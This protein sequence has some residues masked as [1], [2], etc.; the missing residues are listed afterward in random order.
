MHQLSPETHAST[1]RTSTIPVYGARE[2]LDSI[3][4]QMAKYFVLTVRR[5]QALEDSIDQIWRREKQE[6]LRPLKVRLG[7]DEGED[8]LDHGG[9]Q[10]EFFKLVFA[11]AFRTD[12]GMF[13]V[14]SSTHMTWFQPGTVEQLYKFEVIGI[15]TSLAVYNAV[16]LPSHN[17]SCVLS[18]IA[19]TQGEETGAHQGW[20]ARSC[21][22][23]TSA[24]G[25]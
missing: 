23:T 1:L 25:L 9:V 4:P 22:R 21:E 13:D 24:S 8:G 11:E 12:Y 16:T 18:Q 19:W 10:Q 7:K 20:L 6:I 17:A 3:R 2:V 15:L 5:T 14:D